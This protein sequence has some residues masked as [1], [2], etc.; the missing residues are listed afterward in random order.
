[1]LEIWI[2]AVMHLCSHGMFGVPRIQLGDQTSTSGTASDAG[3]ATAQFNLRTNE[4]DSIGLSLVKVVEMALV[5]DPCRMGRAI[6]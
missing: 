4:S 5:P 1:M 6:P 2:A 3:N